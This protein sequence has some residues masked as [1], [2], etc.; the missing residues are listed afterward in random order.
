MKR[1]GTLVLLM[2]LSSSAHAGESFS[3]VVGCHRIRIDAPLNCRS[4]SCVSVSAPGIYHARRDRDDDVAAAPEPAPAKPS[5]AIRA[6]APA[7]VAPVV[8][9]VKAAIAPVA[10]APPAPTPQPLSTPPQAAASTQPVAPPPPPQPVP[11]K[12][13]SIEAP[14]PVKQQAAAPP[15]ATPQTAVR[16]A[17]EAARALS[18][19]SQETT[20]EPADTPLGDW[21]TEGKT[22]T[23]RIEKCGR[24][25]CGYVLN[26][27]SSSNEN[28][29]G[30][31]VL[32]DMKPKSDAQWSGNIYS[33][34]S[35]NTY[36]ARMTMKGAN[37]LRVEACALGRLFCS[38][39]NWT[40]VTA[41]TELVTSRQVTTEPR[42]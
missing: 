12:T 42:S 41:P 7:L 35:G 20:S 4:A 34:S 9:P 38:G 1:L 40:R 5:I 19:V 28:L 31:T 33:R 13:V 17:T 15:I 22:G 6:A 2:A 26:Q 37:T 10:C 29:K 18:K 14:A 24:A 16:P 11:V 30:D 21:Q 3:F 25:L 36:Y 32:I 27:A 8:T 23:V 39:N